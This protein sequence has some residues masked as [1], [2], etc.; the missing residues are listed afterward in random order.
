MKRY[1]SIAL[2][3][4]M[5]VFTLTVSLFTLMVSGNDNASAYFAEE[6]AT[7]KVGLYYGNSGLAYANLQNEVGSGYEF[8]YFNEYRTFVPLGYTDLQKITM[9]KDWNL[10]IT[11][12]SNNKYVD[13][14]PGSAKSIGVVGCFHVRLGGYATF[15]E[16]KA[17]S[18]RHNGGFPSYVNGTF[19]AN[20]GNYT[21]RSDAESAMINSGLNGEVFTGSD[22]CVTV[23]ESGTANILFEFDV[24][25]TG[26]GVMPRGY[27]GE[28]ALTW[29]KGYKYFGGF[30]YLRNSGSNMTVI[31]YVNMEDYV[32]GVLPFEM[33]P[34]WPLEALKAQA[35][36]ART[37]A[38]SNRG[39]HS[40]YAFD[41]C[42]TSDC[43]VYQGQNNSAASIDQA[44][45][46]TAG[47]YV[48]YQ[49]ELTTTFYH[50]SNGGATEDCENVFHEA[51][52]YLR[53]VIDPYEQYVNTG[54][55]SWTVEYTAAQITTVLQSKGY[56]IADV[57]SVTPTYTEL[58]NMFP[59][60]FT[61]SRGKSFTFER[62]A[63]RTILNSSAIG[64]TV[65]SLRYSITGSGTAQSADA[66]AEP[67]Y[68]TGQ[69]APL[70]S[71]DYYAIGADGQTVKI[72][73]SDVTVITASGTT[74]V[75]IGEQGQKLLS[76]VTQTGN[77]YTIRGSGWGHNIGMSQ[78]GA[79]AMAEQGLTYSDIIHFYYTGVDISR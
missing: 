10:Y 2:V 19:Y 52:P 25:G 44:V 20:F 46:E 8:G 75:R 54:R 45:L 11:S 59:L 64:K 56:S 58:G 49:G 63:A 5:I 26:L 77:K 47:E 41:V 21:T 61:D 28:K 16:A 31:N 4:L 32:A 37:Y 17:E 60:K 12:D 51:I 22:K 39:K 27:F 71:G 73:G 78:W 76:G 18:N 62:E 74:Q 24:S 70:E 68:I 65:Y 67:A 6:Y 72:A 79:R 50:S 23:V 7:V 13:E 3:P 48:T 53:G 30:E 14:N 69:S 66:P 57:V 29:F 33:S 55:D 36:C 34:S 9:L 35:V 15:D 43:Q 40:A 38:A 1:I 42:N